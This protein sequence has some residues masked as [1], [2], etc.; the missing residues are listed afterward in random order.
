MPSLESVKSQVIEM[1]A[2]TAGKSLQIGQEPAT[3]GRAGPLTDVSTPQIPASI[4]RVLVQLVQE[5]VPLDILAA[6]DATPFGSRPHAY[7]ATK[8]VAAYKTQTVSTLVGAVDG[9][10]VTVEEFNAFLGTFA[11]SAELVHRAL[12]SVS[13]DIDTEGITLNDTLYRLVAGRLVASKS[14]PGDDASR[15]WLNTA[16]I[17]AA[18]LLLAA[19]VIRFA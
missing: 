2:K 4:V 14:R 17:V 15:L 9:G 6:S 16:I 7:P 5:G 13:Q 11:V 19:A 18:V 8:D 1:L 10:A 12:A 3:P